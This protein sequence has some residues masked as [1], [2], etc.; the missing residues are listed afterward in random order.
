[1][2]KIFYYCLIF[3]FSLQPF[4]VSGQKDPSPAKAVKEEKNKLLLQLNGI[5]GDSDIIYGLSRVIESK[6]DHLS[7]DI[8]TDGTISLLEKEKALRS[9]VFFMKELSESI[10]ERK[11]ELYDIP[12]AID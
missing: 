7:R 9:L 11:M 4:F 1:M 10:T 6:V 2:K 8:S 5:S 3:V 12:G